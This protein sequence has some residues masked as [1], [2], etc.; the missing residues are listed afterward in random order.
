MKTMTVWQRWWI[1]ATV[2][3]VLCGGGAIAGTLVDQGSPGFNPWPVRGTFIVNGT[4]GGVLQTTQVMCAQTAA[5]GGLLHKNT[6]VG[7]A[8]VSTPAAQT[9]QRIYVELCNSTQNAGNPMV[10][11]RVDNTAPVMAAGNAG[12]VLGIGDCKVYPVPSSNV[13][14]CIADTAGTNVTSFE[15]VPL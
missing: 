8:A 1:G 14:Q 11:C 9:A 3:L 6:V 5:D 12:D 13:P 10:K 15:C 4:D 2:V 7:A